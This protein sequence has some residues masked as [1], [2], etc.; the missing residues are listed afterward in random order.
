[1]GDFYQPQYI[2]VTIGKSVYSCSW[3][4][5]ATGK[6]QQNNHLS[7]VLQ[8]STSIFLLGGLVANCLK[9]VQGLNQ[10]ESLCNISEVGSGSDGKS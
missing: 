10:A 9:S 2:Y 4:W 8:K 3:H 1:M 6:K 7:S 5:E